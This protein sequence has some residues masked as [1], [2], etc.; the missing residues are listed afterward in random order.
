MAYEEKNIYIFII[1]AELSKIERIN[2]HIK[3]L[4]KHILHIKKQTYANSA[5]AIKIYWQKSVTYT[6]NYFLI[7]I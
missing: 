1:T 5:F 7:F 4:L 2:C 6:L 3:Y